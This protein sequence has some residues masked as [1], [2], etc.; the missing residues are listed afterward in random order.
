MD[1]WGVKR[2]E[3]PDG[4]ETYL[5]FWYRITHFSKKNESIFI[6]DNLSDEDRKLIKES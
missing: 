6:I 1:E 4:G 2:I 3:Y 5:F